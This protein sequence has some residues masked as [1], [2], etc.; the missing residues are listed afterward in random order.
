[1]AAI[2]GRCPVSRAA[3]ACFAPSQSSLSRPYGSLPLTQKESSMN[4]PWLAGLRRKI[5][6]KILGNQTVLFTS[7]QNLDAMEVG[8]YLSLPD[9]V[10]GMATR[11]WFLAI[12]EVHGR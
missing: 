6:D 8:D 1:M 5:A 2:P 7:R 9:E 12:E 11:R 4:K 3:L 10:L